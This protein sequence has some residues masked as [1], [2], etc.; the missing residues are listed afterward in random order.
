M[1]LKIKKNAKMGQTEKHAVVSTQKSSAGEAG[2]EVQESVPTGMTPPPA[3]DGLPMC[4]IGVEASMTVNLGN[5]ESVRVG[6]SLK[7]PT[8]PTNVEKAYQETKD[9][10][11]DKMAEMVE[12]IKE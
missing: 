4:E 9:W 7:M 2:P 6:V 8:A 12:S 11:E 3:V 10:V 1:A 5:Y